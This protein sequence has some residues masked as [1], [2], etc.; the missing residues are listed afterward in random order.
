MAYDDGLVELL[1]RNHSCLKGKKVLITGQITSMQILS[2][3]KDCTR[4]FIV[5]DNYITAQ[6]LGAAIGMKIGHGSF[7]RVDRK[8]LSLI[9]GSFADP[10]VI[11]SIH[12]DTENLDVL[13]LLLNKNK[14]MSLQDL[15]ASLPLISPQTQ[16]LLLGA[17]AMGGKSADSLIKAAGKVHKLDSARKC[18]LFSGRIDKPEDLKAPKELNDVTFGS[19]TL[20][21]NHGLFSQ[22]QLDLGTHML[23]NAMHADLTAQQQKQSFDNTKVSD[24]KN[25]DLKT[26]PALTNMGTALDL[27]CGSGI[28]A[29]SLAQRG[30]STV[31]AS[32]ISAAALHATLNNA[33]LNGLQSQ[34]YPF[35]C[36]MMPQAADLEN[37]HNSLGQNAPLSDH[38]F[39]IIA[40]NPPFHE[41]LDRSLGP[42]LEMIAQAKNRLLPDGCLYL[43]G[44][45]CLHYE[46]PL[47][48]AFSRVTELVRT[49]KFTVFKA[50]N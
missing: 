33:Q 14:S 48:E 8:H 31:L 40:T 20:Q 6:G 12:D 16:V 49:T 34:I 30:I 3:I 26:L 37:V 4:A 9:F 18:T 28:I 38:K 2:Q 47:R 46:V 35:A 10:Q 45:T 36:N 13:V 21:Q 24:L 43:V 44:N 22:G 27:G 17:N 39:Q 19:L 11:A 23:L 50:Q 29:L 1:N 32:D 5:T 42:T 41:G 7:E 15:H 25:V